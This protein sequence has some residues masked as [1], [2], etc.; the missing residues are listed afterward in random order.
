MRYWVL[1]TGIQ[2][3]EYEYNSL[4]LQQTKGKEEFDA[5]AYVKD[6]YADGGEET[7]GKGTYYFN[8]GE[9]ACWVEGLK[10]ITKKEY[11]VLYKVLHI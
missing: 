6:F 2:N 5:E 7:Y 11:D 10:E 1:K 4:S 8:G 3:G 9:V